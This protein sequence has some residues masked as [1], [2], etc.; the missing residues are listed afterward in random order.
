MKSKMN[1]TKK[2]M[3]NKKGIN[4]NRSVKRGGRRTR[5]K[6]IKKALDK[7]DTATGNVVSKAFAATGNVGVKV[8]KATGQ[9][10]VK[11]ASKASKLT[12][13]A[14]S[15]AFAVTGDAFDKASK[16]TGEAGVKVAKV[17]GEVAKVTGNVVSNAFAATSY[18]KKFDEKVLEKISEKKG[19]IK[20]IEGLKE[21][22]TEFNSKIEKAHKQLNIFKNAYS[23]G[24]IIEPTLNADLNNFSDYRREFDNIYNSFISSKKIV[25]LLDTA[26]KEA[27]KKRYT[28]KNE[29]NELEKSGKVAQKAVSDAQKAVSDAQKAVSDAK[30]KFEYAKEQYPQNL[31]TP[32]TPFN[33]ALID[34]L[35]VLSDAQTVLPVAETTLINAQTKSAKTAATEFLKIV[36]LKEATALYDIIKKIL[37][38][39]NEDKH[40]YNEDKHSLNSILF[41]KYNDNM[42]EIIEVKKKMYNQIFKYKKNYTKQEYETFFTTINNVDFTQYNNLMEL[43]NVIVK[44]LEK[45]Y[46]NDDSKELLELANKINKYDLSSFKDA[47]AETVTIPP[48]APTGYKKNK[49]KI[50]DIDIKF[51][52][53]NFEN[54]N[55]F[56]YYEQVV[57]NRTGIDVISDLYGVEEL[58]P[59]FKEEL[60]YLADPKKFIEDPENEYKF[61]PFKR[62]HIKIEHTKNDKSAPNIN[63]F[64]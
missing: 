64:E 21:T 1:Q 16:V 5:R 60:Q 63:I 23:N 9:A 18:E 50:T 45:I 7:L 15:K 57:L 4:G 17:T 35:N 20:N 26:M 53:S 32:E 59:T 12:G 36:S 34:A 19:V 49:N 14:A 56:P 54:K 62:K 40:K 6:L 58:F 37:N 41:D 52:K 29:A 10:G 24:K 25:K 47:P 33:K 38:K 27:D 3:K 28:A 43:Y 22:V 30:N 11:V 8:A 44:E 2:R 31:N 51:Y 46:S 39:Y 13:D 61:K 55:P 48:I 42:N